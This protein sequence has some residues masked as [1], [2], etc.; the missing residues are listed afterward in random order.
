[1]IKGG[2]FMNCDFEFFEMVYPKIVE[3]IRLIATPSEIQLSLFPQNVNPAQEIV[4]SAEDAVRYSRILTEKNLLSEDQFKKIET[5][6][7]IFDEEEYTPISIL[8]S[9]TWEKAREFARIILQMFS[10]QYAVP[11]LYWVRNVY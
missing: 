6:Y 3:T 9:T 2:L 8:N 11:N 1:M 7:T 4:E 5:L 10:I